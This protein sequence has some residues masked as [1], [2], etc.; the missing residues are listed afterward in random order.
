MQ[1]AFRSKLARLRREGDRLRSGAAA[2]PA[3]AN[4]AA[5]N[6]AA[7]NP[8]AGDPEAVDSAAVDSPAVG[9]AA[10]GSAAAAPSRG[11]GLIKG[12]VGG[13]GM[14][15]SLKARLGGR[16][17]GARSS[18]SDGP[19]RASGSISAALQGG[20]DGLREAS[21][22]PPSG[23][24]EV[25]RPEGT[26]AARE[27]RVDVGRWAHGGWRLHEVDGAAAG[28][29]A[30]LARDPGLAGLPLREAVYLD[31]ET[32]GLSGGAGVYVYMVG[33]GWF[34]GD[35]FVSWQGFLREPGE[36][37]AMLA[38][39]AE[40][41]RAAPGMVSFFGKSFDRHRLE[42]KMRI[43]GVEAPFDGLAHL[44]LYHPLRRL[45]QGTLPD[46][47]LQTMERELLDFH[48]VDD[49]P[50]SLAPAAW[51]DFLADRPHRLEGVF[52]HNHHDVLSLAALAAYLGRAEDE[53][54]VDGEPLAGAPCQRA[55][56]LAETAA[57]EDEELRWI[58]AA[59]NRGAAGESRRRLQVR[60]A[61]LHRRAGR[62]D[63]A[64]AAYRGALEECAEDRHAVEL[65]TGGS[66]LLE[67]HVGDL[68]S[69]HRL[70]ERA[71]EAGVRLG[72]TARQQERLRDRARRLASRRSASAAPEATQ[73]L[74]ESE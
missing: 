51:F 14:P 74:G 43:A 27:T 42:D 13:A 65:F 46:G 18:Q 26:F 35:E 16:T 2:N 6:P 67:R 30:R 32:S 11:D 39:V 38:A 45:T 7:A 73:G 72:L 9:S 69:A 66:M 34:E 5:A 57:D 44:D 61:H 55:V 8:A 70:A 19:P 12:R 1:D 50:G 10:V 33:L 53:T 40:R 64:R 56:A 52:E 31:T 71:L 21:S 23:L 63:A 15:E 59:F 36:E 28:T 29:I 37:R 58:E 49:L 24:M 41:L 68:E 3:A 25:T 17:A 60:Q 20:A 62:V 54:R 47:R 4:P 48:R 22:A